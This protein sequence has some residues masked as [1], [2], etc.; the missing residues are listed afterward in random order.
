MLK[1]KVENIEFFWQMVDTRMPFRYGSAKL[2]RCP[3][4]YMV[5]NIRDA[6]GAVSRG[7]ASDNLPPKWFDKLPEKDFA[8][9]L[10]DQIQ[11]AQWAAESA[12]NA[13]SDTPF[14]LCWTSL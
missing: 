5:A 10:S 8:Q 4:L 7:I 12:I 2:V 1:I 11:V 9:E 3:H 6:V 14:R 13:G